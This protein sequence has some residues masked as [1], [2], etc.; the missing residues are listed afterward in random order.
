M[1]ER[2][3][4]AKPGERL[5]QKYYT[6]RPSQVKLLDE[7]ARR[8]ERSPSGLVRIAIDNL[9]RQHNLLESTK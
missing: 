5:V 8:E 1:Y 7:L 2:V 6:L 4:S 3:P 9:L